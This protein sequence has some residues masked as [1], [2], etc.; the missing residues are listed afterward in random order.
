MRYSQDPDSSYDQQSYM[1]YGPAP[2]WTPVV[3]WLVIINVVLFVL[4]EL[5]IATRGSLA[6]VGG[7]IFGVSALSPELVFRHGF[8]WQLVTY[9][10]MH[11]GLWHILFNMLFLYW[12]GRPIE[13][14]WGAKRFLAFYL[15]A[16]AFAGLLFCGLELIVAPE[17]PSFCVG[18]SGAI[19]A[20]LMVYAIYWPDHMILFMFI[21][22]MR[23]RTFVLITIAI[24]FFNSDGHRP[25]VR[26]RK[27]RAPGRAVLRLRLGVRRA[28]REP[29][30]GRPRLLSARAQSFGRTPAQ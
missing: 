23:M 28:C 14:L 11:G 18:A 21:F 24:E 26:R 3:K 17:R 12:F 9:A 6:Q 8:V 13:A 15:L 2:R 25:L 30:A 1:G 5:T 4:V 19:M 22:P 16:A 10:F 20:L 29:V 27:H 7:L